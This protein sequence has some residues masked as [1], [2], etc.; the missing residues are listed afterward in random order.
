ML[1]RYGSNSMLDHS[2]VLQGTAGIDPS[3]QCLLIWASCGARRLP[4]LPNA[5]AVQIPS[6]GFMQLVPSVP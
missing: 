4:N 2:C 3:R 6:S 1:L 5:A